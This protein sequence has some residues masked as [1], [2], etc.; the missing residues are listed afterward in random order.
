[1]Q[2]VKETMMNIQ[3]VLSVKDL[4]MLMY[5]ANCQLFRTAECCALLDNYVSI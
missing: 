2:R 3:V 1:M 4:G 5:N